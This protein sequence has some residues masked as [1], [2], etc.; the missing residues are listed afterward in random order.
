MVGLYV[1]GVTTARATLPPQL[2]G[3]GDPP[4][5]V[6]TVPAGPIAAVVGEAPLTVRAKRRDIQS[7]QNVIMAIAAD[8]PVLPARFGVIAPD[9]QA[10]REPLEKDAAAYLEALDR[11][12]GRIEMNLKVA[13]AED[14]LADMLRED[15]GLRRLHQETLRRPGYDA[16]IRLGQAVEKGLRRRAAAVCADALPQLAELAEESVHGPDV[17]G[18]VAN[19]SFLIE[20][21]QVGAVQRLVTRIVRDAGSRA[22]FRL[23][24]PLPCYSFCALPAA[25]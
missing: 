8:A 7:H 25:V 10:V 18:Y 4:S 17:D 13:V 19:I 6:S 23:T 11:V 1:Y 5:P 20:S 16:N 14:G 3:V 24:G 2:R 15:E 22:D 12:A 9:E 21:A